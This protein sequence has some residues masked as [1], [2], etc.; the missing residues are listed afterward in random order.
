VELVCPDDGDTVTEG[1]VTLSTVTCNKESLKL[2]PGVGEGFTFSASSSSCSMSL[3]VSAAMLS[4]SARLWFSAVSL[5]L[6]TL[7]SVLFTVGVVFPKRKAFDH[8]RFCCAVKTQFYTTR[9]TCTIRVLN[10]KSPGR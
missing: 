7:A 5:S 6:E 3:S 9:A 2:L 4:A 8:N 1:S 10:E